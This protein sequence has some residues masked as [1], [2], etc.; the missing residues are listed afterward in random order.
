MTR[1]DVWLAKVLTIPICVEKRY[2][3][4]KTDTRIRNT[5]SKLPGIMRIQLYDIEFSRSSKA[6]K[7]KAYITTNRLLYSG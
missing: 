4:V 3:V 5:Q 6:F 1:S 7:H 2:L